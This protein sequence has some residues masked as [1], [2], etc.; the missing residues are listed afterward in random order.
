MITEVGFNAIAESARKY[1]NTQSEFLIEVLAAIGIVLC[2]IRDSLQG[3]Q[4]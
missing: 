1:S 4:E 3:E 2:D